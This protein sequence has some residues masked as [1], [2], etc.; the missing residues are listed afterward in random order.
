MK[1]T[2]LLFTLLTTLLLTA[3]SHAGTD[4]E[5]GDAYENSIILLDIAR[6]EILSAIAHSPE[7]IIKKTGWSRQRL[8]KAIRNMTYE[9]DF[10]QSR[11]GQLLMYD[12]DKNR[13]IIRV[14]RPF[15]RAHMNSSI[16]IAGTKVASSDEVT[17]SNS[18][19]KEV[20]FRLLHELGHLL[21]MGD[22][23]A[24][25]FAAEMY[26]NWFQYERY[27]LNHVV[28]CDLPQETS[29]KF[30][31][32]FYFPTWSRIFSV[33]SDT[34]SS[35][36]FA[37]HSLSDPTEKFELDVRFREYD[38]QNWDWFNPQLRA[39]EVLT[40][41]SPVSVTLQLGPKTFKSEND[42]PMLPSQLRLILPTPTD[43]QGKQLLDFQGQLKRDNKVTPVQCRYFFVTAAP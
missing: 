8:D 42:K 29:G 19:V 10:E 5:G 11:D 24:D 41:S 2:K 12:F 18:E 17:D 22:T 26:V 38:V 28:V 21:N 25:V 31:R 32:I 14:Y 9:T 33:S 4:H 16:K 35:T 27:H 15:F 6:N 30:N 13:E 7:S 3:L 1:T 40:S 34:L 36:G 37:V 23:K 43:S 39:T 20:K